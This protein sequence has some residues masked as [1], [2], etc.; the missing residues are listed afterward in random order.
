MHPRCPSRLWRGREGQQSQVFLMDGRKQ[1]QLP[2]PCLLGPGQQEAGVPSHTPGLGV[3]VACLQGLC[4]LPACSKPWQTQCFNLG[5][6]CWGDAGSPGGDRTAIPSQSPS[7]R[8]SASGGLGSTQ[9]TPNWLLPPKA[10]IAPAQ[11]L[12]ALVPLPLRLLQGGGGGNQMQIWGAGSSTVQETMG[13][14]GPQ[15][16]ADLVRPKAKGRVGD[17]GDPGPTPPVWLSGH[18]HGSAGLG[19]S[20]VTI[21]TPRHHSVCVVWLW[22]QLPS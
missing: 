22:A 17:T 6:R 4:L 16:W 10:S 12:R 18:V 9:G 7:F 2:A 15:I 11:S 13:Q 5:S 21:F 14:G 20:G 3:W 19:D 8:F 1:L